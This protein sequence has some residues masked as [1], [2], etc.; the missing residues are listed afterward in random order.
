MWGECGEL[1]IRVQLLTKLTVAEE[2]MGRLSR[3]M[4]E[5]VSSGGGS[6]GGAVG[7]SVGSVGAKPG[8]FC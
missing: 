2:D 8:R 7:G 4:V 1:R 3:D 6:V 5:Y